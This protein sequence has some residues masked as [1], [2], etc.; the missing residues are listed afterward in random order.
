[1][2]GGSDGETGTRAV[3]RAMAILLEVAKSGAPVEF[4]VLARRCALPKSTVHRIV[5]EMLR[6]GVLGRDQAARVRLGPELVAAMSPLP[7]PDLHLAAT[8]AL[9]MLREETGETVRLA[10]ISGTDI[11]YKLQLDS[12]APVRLRFR[13][14]DHAVPYSSAAGKIA[15]AALSPTT[16]SGILQHLRP[17]RLTPKTIVDCGQLCDHLDSIRRQ[18]FAIDDEGTVRGLRSIGVPLAGTAGAPQAAITVVGPTHRLPERRLAQFVPLAKAAALRVHE[19][20][21]GAT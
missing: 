8:N 13:V 4:G 21:V 19:R 15:L 17:T 5:G 14:G 16:L 11:I 12:P 1:M 9:E 18:G 20:I 2:I 7:R 6:A 3:A 10:T